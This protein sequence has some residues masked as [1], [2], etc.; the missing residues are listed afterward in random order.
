MHTE[1]L[2][3][4][5]VPGHGSQL[6]ESVRFVEHKLT[7]LRAAEPAQMRPAAQRLPNFMS[8]GPHVSSGTD[9]HG[10]NCFR[11]F[12]RGNLKQ[13]DA[14]LRNLQFNGLAFTG[15]LVSRSARDLLGGV[16]WRH[17]SEEHT[18]ELQS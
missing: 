4:L 12:K 2:Q 6:L 7:G 15:Q 3:R 16:G 18:S 17:R 1:T 5:H 9:A 14:D 8:H 11:T 10:E 13:G